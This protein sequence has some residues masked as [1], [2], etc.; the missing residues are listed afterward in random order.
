MRNWRSD[1]AR[2]KEPE[3]VEPKLRHLQHMTGPPLLVNT[4]ASLVPSPSP[5]FGTLRLYQSDAPITDAT[6]DTLGDNSGDSHITSLL[7]IKKQR[8]S[9]FCSR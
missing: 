7:P 1:K 6:A 4:W 5:I 8:A 9:P 3:G 2:K